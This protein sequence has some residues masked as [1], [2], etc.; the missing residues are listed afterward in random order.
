MQLIQLSM[1]TTHKVTPSSK[2][3]ESHGHDL[4]ERVLKLSESHVEQL[5]LSVQVRHV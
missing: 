5:N 2:Y 3:P 4:V 1:Q